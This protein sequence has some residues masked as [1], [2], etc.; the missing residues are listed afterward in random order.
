MA[1]QIRSR[2]T[3]VESIYHQTTGEQPSAVLTRFSRDLE[4]DEQPY[5]RRRRKATPEWQPV[6][7][8]WVE[9]PAMVVI[10]NDERRLLR[11]RA[12][13][14]TDEERLAAEAKVIELRFADSSHSPVWLI[15]PGETMRGS[16]SPGAS[17]RVRCLAGE[18]QYNLFVYPK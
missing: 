14:P 2:L 1:T 8:G 17:L 16:P 10:Q 6:D 15:L 7:Y 4:S 13:N 9:S 3:V 12:T 11:A 5:V 18:A